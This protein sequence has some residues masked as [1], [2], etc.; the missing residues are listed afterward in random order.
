MDGRH[1]SR[2][3]NWEDCMSQQLLDATGKLKANDHLIAAIEQQIRRA[4]AKYKP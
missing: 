2:S 4:T 1:G 3:H